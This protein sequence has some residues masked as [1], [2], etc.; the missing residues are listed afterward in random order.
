MPCLEESEDY[1]GI[2]VQNSADVMLKD[3]FPSRKR[4]VYEYDSGDGWIHMIKLCRVIQDCRE[5]Y[6]R[7]ILAEGDV[8]MEDCGGPDG[9][10]Q[11]MEVLRDKEHPEYKEIA[12]WVRNSLWLPLDVNRIH[13]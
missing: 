11:I 4:I 13:S 12:G 2:Q 8:P 7:C 1:P 10:A 6:P 5:P 3:V 9:F